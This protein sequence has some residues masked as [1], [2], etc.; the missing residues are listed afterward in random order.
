MESLDFVSIISAQLPGGKST[1]PGEFNFLHIS[2]LKSLNLV[3]IPGVTLGGHWG[4]WT[5][6]Y[7]SNRLCFDQLL[8]IYKSYIQTLTT[9]LYKVKNK[10]SSQIMQ[11]IFEKRQ[12]IDYNLRFQTAFV[13]PGVNTTYSGLHSFRYFSSKI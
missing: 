2:P 3:L 7:R 13:L 6:C 5:G 8:Q 9:E 4:T 11:E 12:N 10:L 1:G